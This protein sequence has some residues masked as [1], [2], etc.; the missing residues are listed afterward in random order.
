[1]DDEKSLIRQQVEYY[2]ARAPEYDE[3][4]FREGRYDRGDEHRKQWFSEA[5]VIRGAM[6][7]SNPGKN[8]LELACGTGLWTERLA[9]YAERLVAIDVSPEAID[10]NRRR[11]ADSRVEYIEADL[12]SWKPS[13]RFD[14]IFFAF[15]LSH[16]PHTRF[17]DF[18]KM[19]DSALDPGGQVFF[20]DSLYA[21]ESTA[22]DHSPLELNG[23]ALRRLN[24]GKE[25]E[26][27]KIFYEPSDLEQRLNKLGWSGYIK[28]T[29]R[30]FLYGC[31][32]HQND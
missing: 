7:A 8:I 22:R 32:G 25:Y 19:V 16:V 1:M 9:P 28:G 20:I 26:I 6:K 13:N 17:R 2:R 29:E 11:L 14:F 4:F 31:V 21:P 12:F 30:F 3:W 27:I 10:I 15:W 5:A 23:R 24:D 18:W